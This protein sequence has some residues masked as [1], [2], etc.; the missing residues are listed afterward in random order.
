M[1]R[2]EV[3]HISTFLPCVGEFLIK[4][5]GYSKATW[6]PAET[7]LEDIPDL[8][9]DFFSIPSPISASTC[10]ELWPR[11]FKLL[12]L[13]RPADRFTVYIRTKPNSDDQS[14]IIVQQCKLSWRRG[15]KETTWCLVL[16]PQTYN[17]VL[18]TH[19]GALDPYYI[20]IRLFSTNRITAKIVFLDSQTTTPLLLENFS[21]AKLTP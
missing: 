13:H 16:V 11:V 9:Q 2:F 20:D 8:V 18:N 1:A 10:F 14:L 15:P 4:W 3:E 5:K 21:L 19:P 17:V 6:E 7:I 12:I